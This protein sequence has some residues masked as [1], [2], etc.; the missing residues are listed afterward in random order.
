MRVSAIG[1]STYFDRLS[2]RRGGDRIKVTRRPEGRRVEG[3]MW[4]CA[5]RHMPDDWGW[6]PTPGTIVPDA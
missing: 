3:D 5:M 1:E 6:S 2:L 4:R